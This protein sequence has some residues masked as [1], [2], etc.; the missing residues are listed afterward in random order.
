MKRGI[1]VGLAVVM[2]AAVVGLSI[3]GCGGGAPATP[4]AGVT[5]TPGVTPT[6]A[7]KVITMKVSQHSA[8]PTRSGPR[9]LAWIKALEDNSGGRLKIDFYPSAILIATNETLDAARAGVADM[10][11]IT[12]TYFGDA[13]KVEQ[14]FSLCP[15]VTT[16]WQTS[17]LLYRV[18]VEPNSMLAREPAAMGLTGV[19]MSMAGTY[20][21]F[22]VKK[23]L[24]KIEDFKGLTVTSTSS[25][26]N[27]MYNL[28]NAVTVY[29]PSSEVYES[30]AKGMAEASQHSPYT[31]YDQYRWWELGKPGYYC[32]VGSFYVGHAPWFMRTDYLN[33]LPKDLVD[34]ILKTNYEYL[35]VKNQKESDDDNIWAIEELVAKTSTQI[36]V[37]SDAEKDRLQK[38]IKYPVLLKWA[39]EIEA[40]IPG[41]NAQKSVDHLYEVAAQVVKDCPTTDWPAIIAAAKAKAGK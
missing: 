5:P 32:D 12:V 10:V 19:G 34:M 22:T 20:W 6:A 29:V 4:T 33:S 24:N 36:I 3:V 39:Q 7:V 13:F 2:I 23:Q 27:K 9:T 1:K 11:M 41:F 8:L 26:Q 31:M 25:V 17:E 37:W 21:P 14:L 40:K 35:T 28:L 16:N 15:T 30:L 38:D 18:F